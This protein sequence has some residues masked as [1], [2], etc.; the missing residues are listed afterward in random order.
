MKI[1]R[2][3]ASVFGSVHAAHPLHINIQKSG[4]KAPLFFCGEKALSAFKFQNLRLCAAL[5]QLPRKA[6]F[7]QR[8]LGF[9]IIHNCYSHAGLTPS[10]KILF[11]LY[12][13][14]PAAAQ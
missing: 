1:R 5:I 9:Q 12:H 10:G 14:F 6:R 2:Q 11:R 4:G 8:A 3:S 13:N 7:Q